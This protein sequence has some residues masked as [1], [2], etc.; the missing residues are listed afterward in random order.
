[1]SQ[2]SILG[3]L[4]L[5][6]LKQTLY[7][8]QYFHFRNWIL[9]FIYLFNFLVAQRTCCGL[10]CRRIPFFFFSPLRVEEKGVEASEMWAARS[11]AD[12][13]FFV[14]IGFRVNTRRRV[15]SFIL[16]SSASRWPLWRQAR[17]QRNRERRESSAARRLCPFSRFSPTSAPKQTL[18]WCRI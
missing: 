8:F 18:A 12:F 14:Q 5:F 9:F 1:M 4:S 16:I 17:G 11:A 10:L 7:V 15:T 3:T 2:I 6:V 13:S